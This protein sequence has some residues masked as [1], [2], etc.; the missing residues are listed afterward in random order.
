MKRRALYV[1]CGGDHIPQYLMDSLGDFEEVRLDIDPEWG[2]DIVASILDMGD[3]GQFSFLY[4]SHTLEH[5]YPH[6][7]PIA[8]REFRRVLSDDGCAI[9]FVPNLEGL[10]L[11]SNEVL[12]ESPAGPVTAFDMI[13]GLRAH[14]AERPDTFAHHTGFTGERLKAALLEAGFSRV[15][16]P[17]GEAFKYNLMA[18][19]RK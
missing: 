9:I 13:Y 12:Y 7:V 8:L 16:I 5:V 10:T 18:V 15:E 11:S 6:E 19:A 3:I 14:V 1:G 17:K 2:P 4:T